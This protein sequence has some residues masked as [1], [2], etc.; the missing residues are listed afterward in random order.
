MFRDVERVA[1]SVAESIDDRP[2]ETSLFFDLLFQRLSLTPIS[3]DETL[4]HDQQR[5]FAGSDQPTTLA[6]RY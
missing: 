1:L 3:T 6:V 2:R 4:L 5:P